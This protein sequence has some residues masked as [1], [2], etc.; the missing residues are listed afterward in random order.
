MMI[1]EALH[2]SD[3]EGEEEEEQ[4]GLSQGKGGSRLIQLRS[5]TKTVGA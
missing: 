1:M 4:W 3:E 5:G 2:N